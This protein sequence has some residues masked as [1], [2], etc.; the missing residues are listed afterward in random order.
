M[1]LNGIADAVSSS[2]SITSSVEAA[3]GSVNSGKN[4][5]PTSKNASGVDRRGELTTATTPSNTATP[6]TLSV[7]FSSLMIRP[8]TDGPPPHL[9]ALVAG[10]E[11][12]S[13][14]RRRIP[15]WGGSR[16]ANVWIDV[17]ICRICDSMFSRLAWIFVSFSASMFVDSTSSRRFSTC[18]RFRTMICIVWASMSVRRLSSS[19]RSSSLA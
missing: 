1:T 6:A 4:G 11:A 3:S 14:P 16:I 15:G 10:D 5:S 8:S 2:N 9:L 7:F 17:W 18:S 19:T 13:P 12:K